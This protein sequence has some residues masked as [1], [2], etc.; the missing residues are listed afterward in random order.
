[1]SF[2]KSIGKIFSNPVGTVSGLVT[3]ALNNPLRATLGV[4]TGGVSELARSLPIIGKTVAQSEDIYTATQARYANAITGGL[5]N[6]AQQ[7]VQDLN[8]QR[9]GVTVGPE[10]PYT[11]QQS[12]AEAVRSTQM[13][14]NLGG[15]LSGVSNIFGNSQNPYFSTISDFAGAASQ[16]F[17]MQVSQP[18]YSPM[19]SVSNVPQVYQVKNQVAT[20]SGS[21]ITQDIATI[22]QKILGQLGIRYTLTASGLSSAL[23][24]ALGSIQSL[25][26]RTPSGTVV[27]ILVGLGL[28][29]ME[30]NTMIAWNAQRRK[31]R[32][33]NPA[34]GKAL[35]RAARRI[36]SF[37]R[38][39]T[40]TD[41]IKTHHR[42]QP[43]SRGRC[44]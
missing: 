7:I 1:M 15:L 14:L 37:H 29:A 20:R 21:G 24:R 40:H 44:K 25:A 17:P 26:R 9:I 13:G 4:A 22:G 18:V 28:T 36:K 23:K 34:N 19:P 5:F 6:Q 32:R 35:R 27:S 16:A 42:R 11:P 30:A 39:C 33:M 8:N 41:I 38:L 12:A 43:I 2:F 3:Q 10:I 31:Y